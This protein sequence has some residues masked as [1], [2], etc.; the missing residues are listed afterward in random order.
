MG[1]KSGIL[2]IFARGVRK[3]PLFAW[4]SKL[5]SKD[6]PTEPNQ[7]RNQQNQADGHPQGAFLWA[8]VFASPQ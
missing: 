6:N 8:L 1:W 4:G 3:A 7:P 2:G 5:A